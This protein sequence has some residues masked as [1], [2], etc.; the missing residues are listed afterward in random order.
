MA[1]FDIRV[2]VEKALEL[3]GVRINRE[4]YLRR[5]FSKDKYKKILDDIIKQ[6]P[7]KA[8]IKHDDLEKHAKKSINLETTK[9][10]TLSFLS[11]L[12]GGV[13]MV[14]T[15]PA[16]IVQFYGHVLRVIQK[17]MYLYGWYDINTDEMDDGIT[18][19]IIIFLGV[20]NGVEAAQQALKQLC[21]AITEKTTSSIAAKA[22]TRA[23]LYPVAK[24]VSAQMSVKMVNQAAAKGA[25]KVVPV[26]GGI[27]SGGLT[28]L[29][30]KP[31][32]HR[33]LK[34]LKEDSYDC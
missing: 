26:I 15:I 28:I 10:T 23:A 25:A 22:L 24:K 7:I 20:M 33:L 3:P 2:I 6:G 12:P 21:V 27:V 29:T 32:S 13:A 5:E 30:F 4:E 34:E 8:G 1:N 16:D 9:A 14:G 11:G 17:L 31:M 18:N 19:I